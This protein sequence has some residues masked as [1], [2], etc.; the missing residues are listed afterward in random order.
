MTRYLVRRVGQ[1]IAV[2]IIVTIITFLMLH[3][4]PGG[5]ARAVLGVH[6]NPATI[7]A[8][9]VANGYNLPVV[10]QYWVYFDHLVHGQLGYSYKLNEPVSTLLAMDLPKS[11]YLS[12]LEIGRAHV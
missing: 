7:R 9:N 11:A 5:P 3:L 10:N 6:A 1:S 4:L 12:G 8:F 2:V